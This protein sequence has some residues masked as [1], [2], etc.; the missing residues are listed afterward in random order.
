M[1]SPP[2]FNPESFLALAGRMIGQSHDEATLRTVISR[3]YYSAFLL[4]RH[5]LGKERAYRMELWDEVEAID[6]MLGGIGHRLRK[7]RNK[8]DYGDRIPDL[9][10]E[11]GRCIRRAA[12]LLARI[13]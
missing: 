2:V 9:E 8:A 13:S 10:K 11:A 4:I 6:S 7:L 5:R 3:A 12:V 1:S